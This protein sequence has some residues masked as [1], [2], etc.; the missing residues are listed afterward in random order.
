ML[1]CLLGVGCAMR[2][3]FGGLRYPFG[4]RKEGMKSGD[5][6]GAFVVTA[7]LTAV[8]EASMGNS[9]ALL[10]LA[11]LTMI[12]AVGVVFFLIRRFVVKPMAEAAALANQIASNDLT[13]A[14]VE[15]R[16][17]DEIGDAVGALNKMKIG[18][19]SC[20]ERV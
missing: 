18:R 3:A 15:L 9:L 1:R 14:D 4:Y 2:G 17:N 10:L 20:R 11:A 8:Q 19:A 13:V 16:A 7:P 5:L 6:R 12:L